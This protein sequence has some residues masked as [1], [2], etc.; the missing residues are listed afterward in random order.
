MRILER[1]A[2]TALGERV[3]ARLVE[4][5]MSRRDAEQLVLRKSQG[6][7]KDFVAWVV[8]NLPELYAVAAFIAALFG[9]PLPPLPPIPL[10][11][12]PPASDA[13]T[14]VPVSDSST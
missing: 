5:G 2:N 12:I 13:P 11:P 14:D 1:L 9:I 8:E 3:T 7:F 10:P 4:R 6:S